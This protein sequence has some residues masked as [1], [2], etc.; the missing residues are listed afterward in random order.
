MLKQKQGDISEHDLSLEI[1]EVQRNLSI[2]DTL[3]TEKQFVMKRFPI[4]RGYFICSTIY[5]WTHESSLL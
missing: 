4:F 1:K 2:T 5:I 3:G